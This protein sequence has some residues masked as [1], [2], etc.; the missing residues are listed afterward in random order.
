MKGQTANQA[1]EDKAREIVSLAKA[2][3]NF[4][5]GIDAKASNQKPCFSGKIRELK[6]VHV[7]YNPSYP[8]H[9]VDAK[10]PFTSALE[11][12]VEHEIIHKQDGEGRG[13]PKK[14]EYD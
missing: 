3:N 5:G 6:K 7:S 11:A 4:N 14:K 10:E 13:W 12:V 1:N 9:K 2:R 8:L